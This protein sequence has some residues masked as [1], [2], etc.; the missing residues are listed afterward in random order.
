M[1]LNFSERACDLAFVATA[2]LKFILECQDQNKNL[3]RSKKSERAT[4]KSG[5]AEAN[6]VEVLSVTTPSGRV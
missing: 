6:G 1:L 2:D 4:I 5:V 3:A